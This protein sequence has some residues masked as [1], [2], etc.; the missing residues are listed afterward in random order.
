MKAW[1]SG[2]RYPPRRWVTPSSVRVALKRRL[3]NALP[4][5][6]PS[7]SVPGSSLCAAIARS[8][9]VIASSVRQRSL[10]LQ[11]TISR[12]PAVD[13]G[14]QVRPA[15]LGNPDRGHVEVPELIGPLDPEEART[16][17]PAHQPVALQQPLLAHHPLGPLPVDLPAEL[18]ACERGDHPR[19]VRRIRVGDLDDQPI[20]RVERRTAQ[21]GRPPLRRAVQ[22]RAVDLEHARDDRGPAAL[23]DQLA[24]TGRTC[25]HSHPRNASPA[26]SSS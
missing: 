15:V 24:G 14:V 20:D 12:V 19:P 8:T 6:V 22:A 26:I 16:T 25:S 11:P 18:L 5:S 23:R 21:L 17:T 2:S 3:V 9:S 10:R 1:L 4:L 13:R 7:V